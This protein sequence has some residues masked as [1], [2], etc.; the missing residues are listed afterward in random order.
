[1]TNDRPDLSSEKAP[2]WQNR[3]CQT[4]RI[5]WSWAPDGARHQDGLTDWP[6]VVTELWLDT[7][8]HGYTRNGAT[9]ELRRLAASPQPTPPGTASTVSSSRARKVNLPVARLPGSRRITAEMT[10]R[11]PSVSR[12]ARFSDHPARAGATCYVDTPQHVLANYDHHLKATNTLKEK[13][14]IF[15]LVRVNHQH[16]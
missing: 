12:A 16:V 9:S 3:N 4:V 11:V 15:C 7:S 13:L 1:M 6:S 14:H 10:G 2:D 8:G 5:V